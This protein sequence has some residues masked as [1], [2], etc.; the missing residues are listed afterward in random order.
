M[1]QAGRF[2]QR[3]I[4]EYS[5]KPLL[6]ENSELFVYIAVAAALPVVGGNQLFVGTAVNAMLIL[7]ALHFKGWK[8]FMLVFFPSICA[9]LFSALFAGETSFLL[10][11]L[12]SIWIGNALVVLFFKLFL[13]SGGAYWK[14]L[15]MASFS[16]AAVIG[17]SAYALLAIE[18]IPQSLLLPMS[19]MQLITALLGG[20]VAYGLRL[21][22]RGWK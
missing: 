18:I 20:V 17:L 11:L 16:K 12:P 19:I 21:A 15:L 22:F 13:A 10:Y 5:L 9:Y 6:S 4:M 3:S 14:T 7:S 8:P 2:A 1:E